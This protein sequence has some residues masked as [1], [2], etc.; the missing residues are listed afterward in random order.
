M[1]EQVALASVADGFG[2]ELVTEARELFAE[3]GLEIVMD[4]TYP[5]GTSDFATIINETANSGADTFVAFSYP[6]DTFAL[7]QQSALSDYNPSVFYAGVGVG[8]PAYPQIAQAN[9]EGVMSL[10]GI[11]VANQ[12]IMDYRARQQEVVGSAP[13]YWG[14][15]VTYY[16]LEMLAQA[17]ERVGLDREAVAEELRTGTFDTLMGEV[18]FEGNTLDNIFYLGQW[19]DGNFVGIAP[20]DREGAVEPI[21]PK[22]AWK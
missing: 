7:T 3:A 2:I 13:D 16:A 17:I 11:N 5:L 14:S 20:T 15:V 10:G 1:N 19:Q 22:P 4:T 12:E 8:F 18:K 21:F 9:V 6:P